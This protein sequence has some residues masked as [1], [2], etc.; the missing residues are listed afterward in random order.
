V[1]NRLRQ[2]GA[3][4]PFFVECLKSNGLDVL[5]NGPHKAGKLAR[6]RHHDL[7]A[8]LRYYSPDIT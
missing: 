6:D 2:P 8:V 3:L 5:R 4:P 7:V 1:F